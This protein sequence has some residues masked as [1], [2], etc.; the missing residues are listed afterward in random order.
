MRWYITTGCDG[1]HSGILNFGYC[2]TCG[3]ESDFC[4]DCFRAPPGRHKG[5][6]SKGESVRTSPHQPSHQPRPTQRE[7]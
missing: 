3:G 7:P 6:G 5:G 4:D 1:R 2:E